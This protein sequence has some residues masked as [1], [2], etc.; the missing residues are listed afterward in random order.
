MSSKMTTACIAVLAASSS[1]VGLLTWAVHQAVRLDYRR[2]YDLVSG[3]VTDHA[4]DLPITR[5]TIEP[6]TFGLH[7][8][9][10][11]EP[12]VVGD[13][14]SMTRT[15]VQR[16][17]LHRPLALSEGSQCRWSGI[18]AI[19]PESEY[20]DVVLETSLGPAPAWVVNG[21]SD[22]WAIHV[23]GQ[24]SDR[25]QTLRGVKT[26]TSLD[27]TSLVITY[28]NDG[29]GPSASDGRSHL[30]ETEW[31]DLEDALRFVA[32]QGGTRCVIFGWSLGATIAINTIQRSSLGG[33]I[34]GIVMV[35]PVLRWEDVFRANA[36]HQGWPSFLG[37]LVASLISANPTSRLL[38]FSETVDVK[39]ADVSRLEMPI[40]VPILILH[41]KNDWS[42]PIEAS[43]SLAYRRNE[44]VELVEFDCSGH[45]QEWNSDPVGWDSAVRRWYE[46]CFHT[47]TALKSRRTLPMDI[48]MGFE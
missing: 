24:G 43:R 41:S 33:M 21:G 16:R 22:V 6:G 40:E 44:K 35:A 30:G 7:F 5:R 25:R 39:G 48:R 1:V 10:G 20:K 38:G 15:A 42:V 8:N 26:A 18:T 31:Q 34:R 28:R 37:S 27:L 11:D 4:I 2:H 14:V 29:E 32:A 45:T 23:H 12:A 13:V 9:G 46:R 19:F 17:L 3:R 47:G 36:R